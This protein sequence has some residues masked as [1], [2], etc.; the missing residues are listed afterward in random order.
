MRDSAILPEGTLGKNME[1]STLKEIDKTN[2]GDPG[3][4]FNREHIA[5]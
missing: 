3:G 1:I 5:P 4:V 2:N